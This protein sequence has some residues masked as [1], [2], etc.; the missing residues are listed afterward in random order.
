MVVAESRVCF[1]YMV[2][3]LYT[4]PTNDIKIRKNKSQT[5]IALLKS[6]PFHICNFIIILTLRVLSGVITQ[7][8]LLNSICTYVIG[9]L[10]TAIHVFSLG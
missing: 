7:L 2:L 4:F 8:F 1:L 3:G 5:P 10:K 6:E 9:G